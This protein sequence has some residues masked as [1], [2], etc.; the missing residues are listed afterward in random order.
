VSHETSAHGFAAQWAPK[1]AKPD[2]PQAPAR[3]EAPRRKSGRKTPRGGS[4]RAAAGRRKA[5]RFRRRSSRG[6]PSCEL[7][8]ICPDCTHRDLPK[9]NFGSAYRQ[10]VVVQT[11]YTRDLESLLETRTPPTSIFERTAFYTIVVC[12]LGVLRKKPG[13]MP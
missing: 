5:R 11:N 9:G 4:P 12:F 6:P 8:K 7:K 13:A 1:A 2:T 10:T 3:H